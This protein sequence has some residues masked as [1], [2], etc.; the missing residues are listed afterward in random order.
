MSDAKRRGKVFSDWLVIL[1][2]VRN[3]NPEWILTGNGPCFM[4]ISPITGCYE[5]VEAYNERKEDE[6]ALR[7]LPSRL[8]A[9]ELVRRIAVSQE[10][11]FCSQ[12]E[13]KF[14]EEKSK[15]KVKKF[16]G[17]FSG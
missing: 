16:A 12:D 6:K 5:S 7:R 10:K 11:V 15:K 1:M 8:L 14:F 13:P 17:Y 4:P 3:V 2:R 9:D